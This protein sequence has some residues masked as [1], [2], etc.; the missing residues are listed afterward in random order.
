[1]G[2]FQQLVFLLLILLALR[3]CHATREFSGLSDAQR[4]L[5]ERDIVINLEKAQQNLQKAAPA[6]FSDEDCKAQMSNVLG[7]LARVETFLL[8]DDYAGA[9]QQLSIVKKILGECNTALE[10]SHVRTLLCTFFTKSVRCQAHLSQALLYLTGQ[11]LTHVDAATNLLNSLVDK[12]KLKVGSTEAPCEVDG[13]VCQFSPCGQGKNLPVCAL[14]FAAGVVGGANGLAYVVTNPQDDDPKIPVPGTLRYGVSL[15]NS[16]GNGVWITFAG[17][18]TIFLQEML[19]IRSMTT[20]DGRGFNVTI[21]GRN[22]VLGGVSNVILHNLQISS[23]GESDTIHIYA[24]SKKIWVDHVSS[25]DAR[26][27]L[28]SVLQGSTDVTISN[29][30]LTNLN[31]NMLLGASDADTEDKIMRVTVYRNWFKDSTQ[32]MPHCR[33]GYCHVINNL[34][35]NW[36]YYAIGGRVNAKIL[37]DNNV[38]VAGRRSEVTPWFSLHGPEFDTTATITSSNDLFLNGSTFHQFMGVEPM[39]LTEVPPAYPTPDHN[40]PIHSTSTLPQFLEQCAGAI[41]GDSLARC[42]FSSSKV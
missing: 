38:F 17:N 32:R 41:F 18:M 11:A 10:A 1:M 33:W 35:T 28:V 7:I 20:I 4:E 6:V 12:D 19:W 34:Y 2:L 21:T 16:D 36:G 37:S 40:P 24:G 26:L 31:F 8:Q 23:V 22:L 5:M 29:S 15:G 13:T 3:L 9:I 30:L 42:M 27:G 14:G 39:S 25:W